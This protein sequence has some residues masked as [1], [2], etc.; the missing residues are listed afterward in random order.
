MAHSVLGGRNERR[1]A[2]HEVVGR[3]GRHRH[4][5][6]FEVTNHEGVAETCELLHFA[7]DR[8]TSLGGSMLLR[9]A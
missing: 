5:V 7:V 6:C 1:H 3:L 4:L 9:M 8:V 2:L